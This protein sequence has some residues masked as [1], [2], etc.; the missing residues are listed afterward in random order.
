MKPAVASVA[1]ILLGVFLGS[2]V[3]AAEPTA[4]EILARVSQTYKNLGSYQIE[5]VR[6]ITISSLGGAQS[7]RNTKISLTVVKPDKIRLVR[8]NDQGQ[9]VIVSNGETTW[10]Y[11]PA[12]KEYSEESG[13]AVATAQDEES[14][15]EEGMDPLAEAQN[16]VVGR[17]LGISNLTGAELTGRDR[18]KLDGAKIDCLIAKVE[19]QGQS[20]EMW[21]DPARFLVL[22]HKISAKIAR[23]GAPL[24]LRTVITVKHLQLDVNPEESEFVFAPPSKAK[25]VQALRIPGERVSLRGKTAADF[26]LKALEGSPLRLSDL[27]G[28]IVVIDFWATWCAPCREELPVL[29]ELH[30]ELGE[31]G[32]VILGIT[33]EDA[34]TIKSFLK[35]HPCSFTVLMDS[36]DQ[37]H[38]LYATRAIPTI[39]VINRAGVVVAHFVGTQSKDELVQALRNAGL[40]TTF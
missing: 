9:L 29:E 33:D 17:Y 2:Q 16:M 8:A 31:R 20:H 7:Y 23:H 38:K 4:G 35:K 27:R 18:I 34:G 26:T 22:R 36:K 13:A 6:G 19:V 37:A 30:K 12:R 10:T 5:A 39:L 21:I 14:E 40:Q 32:V 3:H 1:A 25:K 15:G 24:L 28:K 11:L